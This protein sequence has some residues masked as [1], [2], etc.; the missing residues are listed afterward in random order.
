MYFR[1][2]VFL[3]FLVLSQLHAA[4]G[5]DFRF[6]TQLSTETKITDQFSLTALISF[7]FKDN[8]SLLYYQ[9]AQVG[10]N[11][12]VHENWVVTPGYRQGVERVTSS[13]GG[14]YWKGENVPLFDATGKW[15]FSCVQIADRNRFQ[16][17]SVHDDWHY[18]NQV[19]LRFPRK[20]SLL[21]ITPFLAEEIFIRNAKE[22][23]QNRFTTGLEWR[24]PEWMS[25]FLAYMLQLRKTAGSLWTVDHVLQFYV[26][27]Y[28][29][30]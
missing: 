4:T 15:D 1:R 10:L 16:Y 12:K 29:N 24:F 19:T 22:F 7:R 2:F 21:Q 25:G 3:I 17:N 13:R 18:R 26:Y 14:S 20:D 30:Q 9:Y 28:F 5:N 11:F 23:S 8:A 27:T 6:W